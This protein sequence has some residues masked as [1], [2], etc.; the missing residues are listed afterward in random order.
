MF[1]TCQ[2][3]ARADRIRPPGGRAR[4]TWAMP[5]LGVSGRRGSPSV[6]TRP[7]CGDSGKRQACRCGPGPRPRL[8]TLRHDVPGPGLLATTAKGPCAANRAISQSQ[9]RFRAKLTTW[10][11]SH[12]QFESLSYR[13]RLTLMPKNPNAPRISWA[14][15]PRGFSVFRQQSTARYHGREWG[16]NA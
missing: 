10:L 16:V 6:R 5:A 2:T 1:V 7:S 14:P 4:R 9:R 12:L 3:N 8:A 15:A 11:T 13:F